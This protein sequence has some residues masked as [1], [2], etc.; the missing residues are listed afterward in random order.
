MNQLSALA[1]N[2]NHIIYHYEYD[3]YLQPKPGVV[4]PRYG[5]LKSHAAL[6]SLISYGLAASSSEDFLAMSR[7]NYAILSDSDEY[8]GSSKVSSITQTVEGESNVYK[9]SS[10][11]YWYDTDHPH[12]HFKEDRF[13][14]SALP[15]LSS[16]TNS[17]SYI[18]L[19]VPGAVQNYMSN[20]V[21]KGGWF[22]T[23]TSS[24]ASSYSFYTVGNK[25]CVNGFYDMKLYELHDNSLLNR[26]NQLGSFLNQ[27]FNRIYNAVSN[28]TGGSESNDI[29]N[30]IINDYDVDVDTD[31]NLII[32]DLTDAN[33]EIDLT[34]PAFT[35]DDENSS[36][37]EMLSDIPFE[38]IKVFTDNKLGFLIF[39]P[40]VIA[41]LRLIL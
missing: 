1:S 39:V 25:L 17:E 16:T 14:S 7:Y 12:W 4:M 36:N 18:N 9:G 38:T 34:L 33:E 35:I 13:Y 8:K 5:Y 37:V 21:S 23:I 32:G 30:N 40:I 20:Y 6:G 28:I 31:F 29:T 41:V 27:W 10:E 11:F 24:D 26:F 2:I 22:Y 19:T 3:I 15:S